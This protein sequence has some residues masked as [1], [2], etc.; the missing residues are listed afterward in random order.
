MPWRTGVKYQRVFKQGLHSGFFEVARGATGSGSGSGIATAAAAAAAPPAPAPARVSMWD[1]AQ[2]MID[3]G[4]QRVKGAG[5]RKIEATDEFREPNLWLRRISIAIARQLRGEQDGSN[6][7]GGCD[8]DDVEEEDSPWDLQAGHGTRV[9]SMVYA[10]LLS[11][12]RF[13]M[14]S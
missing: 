3:E 6:G 4:L 13:E 2:A 12:G 10:R 7:H 8:G 9:A 1:E 14:Q 5:A 11:E